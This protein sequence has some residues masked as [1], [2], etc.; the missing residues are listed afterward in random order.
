MIALPMKVATTHA[1]ATFRVEAMMI[2]VGPA[3]K[4]AESCA[5]VLRD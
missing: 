2:R 1:G 3:K 4:Q 5:K